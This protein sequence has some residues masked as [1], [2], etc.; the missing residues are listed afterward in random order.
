MAEIST[1][2]LSVNKEN[3]IKTFYNLEVAKTNYYH[4]DVMDGKF[5][6]K[7]NYALMKDYM[8]SLKHI[9]NLPLDV[10]LMVEDVK[11]F[12]DEFIELEPHIITFHI[13]AIKN[14]EEIFKII[15]Y[16]K[17]RNVK[18]GIAI[19]P[20]TD[21][22]ELYEFLPYIHMVLIM[23]VEPGKGGQKLIKES[24]EKISNLYKY[25]NEKSLE[26]DIEADGGIKLENIKFVKDAGANIIVVGTYIIKSD[27]YT[28][29]I[30]QLKEA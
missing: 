23:T 8:L 14:K 12:V 2:V 13:E 22:E 9:T 26:V 6:E 5:V 21:I 10:H 25:L 18:V 7:N 29:A 27:D 1:S 11:A 30:K 19:S 28:K 17:E 24:L 15:N 16:I 20:N 3:A 4:I